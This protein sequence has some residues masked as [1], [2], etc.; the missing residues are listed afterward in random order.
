MLLGHYIQ[1]LTTSNR[2]ALPSRFRRELGDTVVLARWYEGCLAIFPLL[3]WAKIIQ[4]ATRGG[5]VTSP[6]RDTERFLLGGAYELVLDAQGR[7]IIPKPLRAYAELGDEVVF[8]GLGNRIEVWSKN[9]W[10]EHEQYVLDN[11]E[12]MIEEIQRN[13]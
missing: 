11:A 6:A 1:K 12:R 2:T 8:V 3:S 4:Q 5:S 13:E 7:F 9:R 10:T